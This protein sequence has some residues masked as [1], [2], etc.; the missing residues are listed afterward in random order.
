MLPS[1]I[2]RAKLPAPVVLVGG[3]LLAL[4]VACT[5]SSPTPTGSGSGVTPT[6]VATGPQRTL[7]PGETPAPQ[8]TGG[9]T[10]PSSS[11]EPVPSGEPTTPPE[12]SPTAVVGPTPLPTTAPEPPAAQQVDIDV[13]QVLSG[14]TRPT[15]VFHANDERL[16]I[17]EQEGIIKVARPAD[18]GGYELIGEFLD[19]RN[20]IA[21]CGERGLLGLAFHPNYDQNGLFYIT[22][23]DEHHNFVLEERRVSADD[24]NV[25]DRRYR[26]TLLLIYKPHDYHW[27]GG[28]HFGRDGYLWLAM[29]DGG[30]LRDLN[31][32]GDPDNDSQKLSSL[33]G[34]LLRIDVT[35]PDGEGPAT[36]GIPADNPYVGREGEDEIWARGLRNPWRWSFD[37]WTGDLWITD[38]GHS[39]WEEVNRARAPELGRGRNY[40]WRLKEGPDCYIPATNCDPDD[41]TSEPLTAYRHNFGSAEFMCA[42]TGGQVYRGERFPAMQSRFFFADYC[43]GRVLSVDAGGENRQDYELELDTAHTW[44]GIG[45][46]HAGELYLTELEEGAIYLITGEGR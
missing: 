8:P 11:G 12:A 1:P 13:R 21:C 4:V 9:E 18:G 16:F 20:R 29:G 14:L 2:R 36:Y 34:K 42:I 41:K 15:G 31:G 27:G 6:A 38:T 46:D 32:I 33:Y 5:T 43:S 28:I 23:S 17:V 10:T 19:S 22:Y 40:G 7:G 35:D 26:R 30:F 24:P 44:S 37:R 45:D 25:A 3:A 39:T